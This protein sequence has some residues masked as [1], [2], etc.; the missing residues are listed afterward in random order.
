MGRERS[1]RQAEATEGEFADRATSATVD[2]VTR[3]QRNMGLAATGVVDGPT[4]AALNV[5]VSERIRTMQANIARLEV[6]GQDLGDRYLVVNVPSQQI[7]TVV[8]GVPGV[9]S[10]RRMAARNDA[11]RAAPSAMLTS[12]GA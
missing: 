8:K 11:A 4:L 5:P 1:R 12:P 7:E 2:A 9:T 10:A 3:Y 6:Y